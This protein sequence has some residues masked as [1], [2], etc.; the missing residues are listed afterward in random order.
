MVCRPHKGCFD[1]ELASTI[2]PDS[3]PGMITTGVIPRSAACCGWFITIWSVSGS[4]GGQPF[5]LTDSNLLDVANVFWRHPFRGDFEDYAVNLAETEFT[6]AVSQESRF[7]T[8][9]TNAGVP[10]ANLAARTSY[11]RF[12]SKRSAKRAFRCHLPPGRGPAQGADLQEGRLPSF[13]RSEYLRTGNNPS[14]NTAVREVHWLPGS[15]SGTSWI[16]D[17]ENWLCTVRISHRWSG[18]PLQHIVIIFQIW[19][20]N[21]RM[22]IGRSGRLPTAT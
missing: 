16:L 3:G 9:F 1:T 22:F 11:W 8:E 19:S 6:V 10:G 13:P 21:H 17:V 20:D 4:W 5:V 14:I 7:D 12:R 2:V 18:F 15:T